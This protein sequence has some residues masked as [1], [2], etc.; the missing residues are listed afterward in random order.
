MKK[1]LL[2]L[3]F[4]L[5]SCATAPSTADKAQ[6]EA[7]YQIGLSYMQEQ[8]FQDAFVEL[9]KSIKTDPDNK[10]ALNAL[11]LIYI[12][13]EDF[14]R[15]EQSF[16]DALDVDENFSD[17]YH[18]LGVVYTRKKEWDKSIVQFE[19]ALNNPLYAKPETSYY[20]IGNAYYRLKK[21][22]MAI[23]NYN[24]SLRRAPKFYPAYYGLA[25]CYNMIEKYGDAAQFLTEGI[26]LDPGIQG[27][28]RKAG[29]VFTAGIVMTME[30]EERKDLDDLREILNY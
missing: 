21:Y 11:G 7:F 26:K 18:N 16:L 28:R 22:R 20:N 8:R 24:H 29:E 17:A 12:K 10:E 4:I 1:L 15:A 13:F 25:L 14:D 9:Q 6:S 23:K 3:L 5:M 30:E 19:N 27:N 2:L